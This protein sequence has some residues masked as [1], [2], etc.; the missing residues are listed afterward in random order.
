V[1]GAGLP[2]LIDP[3]HPF[4]AGICDGAEGPLG[5]V[6]AALGR[7]LAALAR[8][9]AP[10]R[11]PIAVCVADG[12]VNCVEYAVIAVSALRRLA[13][14]AAVVMGTVP[15]TAPITV[16][17]V[18]AVRDDG[19]WWAFDVDDAQLRPY[20]DVQ[21]ALQLRPLVAW[22]DRRSVLLYGDATNLDQLDEG[23]GGP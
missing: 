10:G 15:S 18:V 7:P 23:E 5:P 11:R 16:H 1:S 3:G 19:R 17:A 21:A 14:T 22:H 8:R 2:A 9:V 4:V 20:Q 13:R 12:S 6:V